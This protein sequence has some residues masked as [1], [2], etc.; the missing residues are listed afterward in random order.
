MLAPNLYFISSSL[1]KGLYSSNCPLTIESA[2]N[3]NNT[4]YFTSSSF[5]SH[6]PCRFATFA[7]VVGIIGS[8]VFGGMLAYL[9]FKRRLISLFAVNLTNLF[10]FNLFTRFRLLERI[11]LKELLNKLLTL[12]NVNSTKFNKSIEL[13]CR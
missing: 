13:H 7:F 10:L 2:T 1:E 6:G 9:F 3:I 11:L 5:G 12:S 8:S 4:L